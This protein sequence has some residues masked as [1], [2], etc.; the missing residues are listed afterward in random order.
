MNHS[1]L[2]SPT[3]P[4]YSAQQKLGVD[5]YENFPVASFLCPAHLRPA[6]Q[7]LYWFARI[8][9]DIAD[10]G[11][12]SFEQRLQQLDAYKA[13]LTAI[14][15]GLPPSPTWGS[16]FPRLAIVLKAY[17]IE[18]NYLFDLL[19]AFE[20][21]IVYTEKTHL[22][23]SRQDLLQYCQL[24]ANPVGRL[25]LQMNHVQN[26]KAF[27]KSDEVCS[28]LQLI[29]FWQDVS[30]DLARKRN[31]LPQNELQKFQ[32]EGSM[33]DKDQLN[34]TDYHARWASVI[35]SEV[36]YAVQ[37]LQSGRSVVNYLPLRMAWELRIV[38]AGALHVAQQIKGM[39]YQTFLKRPHLKKYDYFAIVIKAI[40]GFITDLFRKKL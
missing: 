6:V 34:D 33:P 4:A 10:E 1:Q 11:E 7:A 27:L 31:Y 22:Y 23:S 30:K 37:L 38:I 20:Q 19:A 16:I 3:P 8:G 28:G 36:N 15:Q 32:L 40:G 35:E 17:P 12:C 21:D 9:D 29:N 39:Q 14:V 25:M 24:S 13:D 5:H 26:P 18:A 2:N